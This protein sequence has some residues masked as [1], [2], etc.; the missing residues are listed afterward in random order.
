MNKN[1]L[2]VSAR[3]E[4]EIFQ[5]WCST[6]L[7]PAWLCLVIAH[8][9]GHGIRAISPV[10][11]GV[12]REEDWRKHFEGICSSLAPGNEFELDLAYLIAWQLWRFGRLIRHET[13]LT[14]EKIH[15]PPESMFRPFDREQGGNPRCHCPAG[16][17]EWKR[18]FS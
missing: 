10:L 14:T 2:Q 15:E 17:R 12:E 16:K 6:A 3:G 9:L 18:E 8:K 1:V 11:L 5:N 7:D 13:A 4:S